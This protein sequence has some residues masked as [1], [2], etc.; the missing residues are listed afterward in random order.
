MEDCD[1]PTTQLPLESDLQENAP[2][3]S[4][5]HEHAGSQDHQRQFEEDDDNSGVLPHLLINTF[6][7]RRP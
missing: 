2:L 4:R 7:H 6:S 1:V 5:G 3:P